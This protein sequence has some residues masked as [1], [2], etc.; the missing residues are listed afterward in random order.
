MRTR[1]AAKLAVALCLVLLASACSRS[2]DSKLKVA[3]DRTVGMVW[4]EMLDQRDK[5]H[6][7][8]IKEPEAVTHQDCT[9]LGI[10]AR[11]MDELYSELAGIIGGQSGSSDEGRLRALGDAIGRMS[12]VIA[13]IRESALAEAPGIW[14]GLRYP[15]DQTM[16]SVESY[17]S[18]EELNSQSVVNRPGFEATPP[19]DAPSAV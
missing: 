4:G 2:S 15:L 19:P 6:E 10:A 9:D 12:S 7:I 3:S 16:R 14:P 17:F 11:R 5:I 18:A 13:R 8:F 1:P